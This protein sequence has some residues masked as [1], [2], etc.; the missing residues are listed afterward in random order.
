MRVKG[1]RHRCAMC[2][3]GLGM[4]LIDV[5]AVPI[6]CNIAGALGYPM[7]MV[8]S[9]QVWLHPFLPDTCIVSGARGRWRERERVQDMAIAIGLSMVSH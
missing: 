5:P 6:L 9:L 1:V 3:M 2:C 8:F 4:S 7:S